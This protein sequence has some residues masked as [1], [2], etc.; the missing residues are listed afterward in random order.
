[1]KLIEVVEAIASWQILAAMKVS[2]RVAYKLLKYT[3]LVSA[4]HE[5]A[6]KQ[7]VALIH[8]LTGTKEGEDAS[9]PAGSELLKVYASRLSDILETKSDLPQCELTLDEVLDA[10]CADQANALSTRDLGLLE[11]FF[12]VPTE[13]G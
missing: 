7:R 5:I 1:M 4:E 8:E 13:G 9:I 11:P 3:K 12:A 2:P 10:V 6:E